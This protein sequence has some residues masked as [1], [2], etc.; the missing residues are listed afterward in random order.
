M[1]L[2]L[3]QNLVFIRK[4]IVDYN[5]SVEFDPF[6]FYVKDLQMGLVL[7][8]C[9]SKCELYSLTTSSPQAPKYLSFAAL[10]SSPWHDQLAHPGANILHS[11]S[12]HKLILSP[13]ISAKFTD[14][15][16][17]ET[18]SVFVNWSG[19]PKRISSTSDFSSKFARP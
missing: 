14:P 8:R 17:R 1:L 18:G 11:L 3:L 2:I 9:E 16:E 13:K 7:M 12:Q 4:F 15:V 10:P 6:G 19:S 5:V